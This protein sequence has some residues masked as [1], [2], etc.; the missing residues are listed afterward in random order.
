MRTAAAAVAG[1]L[2]ASLGAL[3]LGEYE[4]RGALPYVAGALFGLAVAEAIITVARPPGAALAAAGAVFAAAGFVWAAWIES[5][6]D[7]NYVEAS[8]WAGAL[9]AGAA[10]AVWIRSFGTRGPRTPAPPAHTPD[11]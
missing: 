5:G 1:A 9:I 8:G 6:R 7:W 4:L 11:G 3:I 2:V 10:A